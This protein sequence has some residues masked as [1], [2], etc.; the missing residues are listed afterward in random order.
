ML[1]IS[2]VLSFVLL[3]LVL[4]ATRSSRGGVCA[5]LLYGLVVAFGPVC[6]GLF[7][8]PVILLYVF[9]CL[10]LWAWHASGRRQRLWP[11][12]AFA[13]AFGITGLFVATD[14][15]E[16]AAL[17]QEFPYQSMEKLVPVPRP[18]LRQLDS[19]TRRPGG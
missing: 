10:S 16:L 8:P 15:Q 14:Q 17:R 12:V 6:A 13:G 7:L 19:P 11:V 9:L 2:L 3:L 1:F 5:F 4:W 18:E